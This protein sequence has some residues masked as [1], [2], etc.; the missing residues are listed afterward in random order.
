MK[1]LKI[2]AV[3]SLALLCRY[4]F[5]FYMLFAA[6]LFLFGQQTKIDSVLNQIKQLPETE[7]CYLTLDKSIYLPGDTV[8]FKAY[9]FSASM[10]ASISK[11]L[12]V[13]AANQKG[14]VIGHE[15]FPVANGIAKGQFVIPK[16][17]TDSYLHIQAYTKYMHTLDSTAVYYNVLPVYQPAKSSLITNQKPII[18]L[19]L[20]PEGGNMIVDMP[21][22]IA[23]KVTNQ[24][25][26]PVHVKGNVIDNEGSDLSPIETD[27]NGMGNLYLFIDKDKTYTINCVDDQGNKYVE[28]LNSIKPE[29]I[30]F[31]VINSGGK[32]SF[33]LSRS[34]DA[35]EALIKLSLVGLFGNE[36][37]FNNTLDLKDNLMTEGIIA[38]ENLPA[39]I[40]K[41]MVLDS[42]GNIL[43][44]RNIFNDVH[45]IIIPNIVDKT[46][47]FTKRAKNEIEV[48]IPD[49]IKAN[50]S[51]S[52]VDADFSSDNSMDIVN[53][54]ALNAGV[55]NKI[56]KPL[57][58]FMPNS[59]KNKSD[60][61]LFM[62]AQSKKDAINL[63]NIKK[64]KVVPDTS[65]L[66]FSGQIKDNSFKSRGNKMV[67]SLKTK[68]DNT[69]FYC[70]LPISNDGKFNKN[71]IIFF[72]TLV[73]VYKY[74]PN[75]DPRIR[76]IKIDF[77]QNR[78][79]AP[80]YMHIDSNAIQP[81]SLNIVN[82]SNIELAYQHL[83]KSDNETR[84][85]QDVKIL[86]KRKRSSEELERKYT[87]PMYRNGN[88][89]DIDVENDPIAQN[90]FDVFSYLQS[91]IP[92]LVINTNI[93]SKD[94]SSGPTLTWRNERVKLYVDEVPTSAQDVSFLDLQGI[95]Y[96]KAIK[97]SSAINS[98]VI[99][100][101]TNNKLGSGK[102]G[103]QSKKILG[104]TSIEA[105][106]SPDY[107][108]PNLNNK[109]A[110]L[111]TTLFWE[112]IITTEGN[113]QK[114]NISFYNNDYSKAYKVIVEGATN[115]GKLIRA[116]K[117][118]K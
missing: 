74:P 115:D 26:Q 80:L 61:D 57:S 20:Y 87:S 31:K 25:N 34:S 65:Y 75:E 77:L 46:I 23:F 91:K 49:S 84:M 2:S 12:Y 13:D 69:P 59:E 68:A 40:L 4:F 97:P 110:D 117:L 8:W 62:L 18:K 71:G 47:S 41:L 53:S 102:R 60:L 16:E 21:N 7:K 114:I 89:L 50:I 86:G 52:V 107:S 101:Y 58:Y 108:K 56:E 32:C 10:Q 37:L 70:T 11:N 96:I 6:P 15:V 67:F 64:V 30:V 19:T 106:Y 66:Y 92:G 1:T 105:F 33:M 78:L 94:L 51:V 48:E 38:T 116:E 104:Y 24:F 9:V 17:Y 103:E 28:K 79:P 22:R 54:V 43:A 100:I 72:D 39:G 98:A 85:L 112:P 99:V 55:K 73:V 88:S 3:N 42:N 76:P 109:V 27:K 118:I 113:N 29:G 36:I 35:S 82:H 83:Q 81:I 44:E 5:I 63:L 95:A 90:G 14:L 45:Q 93:N 111:R